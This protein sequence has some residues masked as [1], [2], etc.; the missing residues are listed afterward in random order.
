M[1]CAR[2]TAAC[3]HAPRRARHFRAAGTDRAQRWDVFLRARG[4]RR[5]RSG[6][7]K[8]E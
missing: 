6:L 1:I 4:A 8:S 7:P 3:A 5:A 2:R